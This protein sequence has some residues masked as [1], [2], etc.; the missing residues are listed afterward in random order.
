[1]KIIIFFVCISLLIIL[2]CSSD[3]NTTNDSQYNSDGIITGLD[4]R[5]CACCGGWFID[6]ADS[7]YRF[8]EIPEGS[9]I[10]LFNATLP[11]NVYLDW[12]KSENPCLGDEI[13]VE[14]ISKK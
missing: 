12:H 8:Y 9:N 10:D 3:D 5:E 11:M 6:I 13:I 14:R 7:T 1:M 2:S 4:M